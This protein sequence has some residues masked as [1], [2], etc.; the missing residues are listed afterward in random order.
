MGYK[1]IALDLDDTLLD[2]RS[3]I[4]ERVSAAVKKAS[5]AGIRVV[6]STGRILKG[7]RRFYDR[8]GLDTLMITTG[9]AEIYD[10]GG[11]TIFSRPVEPQDTKQILKLAQERG[12]YAQVYVNGD[13]LYREH[14]QYSENYQR[15]NGFSGIITPGLYELENIVSSKVILLSDAQRVL[16]FQPVAIKLFPQLA[17]RRSQP[18]YLEFYHADVSKGAAMKFVAAHYGIDLSDVVAIGD[19][20]IDIPMI[21]A[22]GLGVAVENAGDEIKKAAN[23]ICASNDD[24]GVADVIEKILREGGS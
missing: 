20:Q 6:L 7:M 4:P 16:D 10:S 19:S 2:S 13:V 8:L 24:G 3:E 12:F 17:I 18:E 21:Q 5:A 14:N 9:G 11:R 15:V 1:M 23:M 22:A